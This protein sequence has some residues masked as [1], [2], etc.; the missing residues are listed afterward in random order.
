VGLAQ[1]WAAYDEGDITGLHGSQARLRPQFRETF[2]WWTKRGGRGM[3]CHGAVGCDGEGGRG[4]C[5]GMMGGRGRE[6]CSLSMRSGCFRVF[7]RCAGAQQPVRRVFMTK[8]GTSLP[9][10]GGKNKWTIADALVVGLRGALRHPLRLLGVVA[11]GLSTWGGPRRR[12]ACPRGGGSLSL[13]RTG[14][15]TCRAPERP[16]PGAFP[17]GVVPLPPP[18]PPPVW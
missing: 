15:G 9:R 18:Q 3:Q 13:Q 2:C 14:T 1:P 12:P 16:V 10:N 5:A 7:L 4:L 17:R 6:L 8:Q 11:K